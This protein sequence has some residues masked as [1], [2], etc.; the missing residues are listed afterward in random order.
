MYSLAS[1]WGRRAALY[2]G[3]ILSTVIISAS[4][5]SAQ[6]TSV[7]VQWDPNSAIDNVL[8]YSL[9]IDTAA[10]INVA[11]TSCTATVCESAQTVP[12]GNHT[13]S[14]SAVNQWGATATTVTQVIAPPLPPKNLRIIKGAL[15][16]LLRGE[17]VRSA[18]R[19]FR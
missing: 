4:I 9:V 12:N 16:S 13:F 6:T 18:I 8:S 11:L 17:P 3:I 14:V 15:L 7:R 19:R 10:P 1:H 2:L 5:A